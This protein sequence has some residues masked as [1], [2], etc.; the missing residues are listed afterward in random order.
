[1]PQWAIEEPSLAR[2]YRLAESAH[3]AQPRASD[4]RPFLDHVIE[5]A[6]LLR[7]AGLDT[8]LVA[9]GLLHD[10]VERGTLTEA[11]LR[12]EM[13]ESISS[14][15]M[16]LSEDPAIESF[17][18]RKAALR[19]QV[20]AA[21]DRAMTVFAA[22]KLSDILGLRRGLGTSGLDTLE[23]RLGTTVSSMTRHYEESVELVRSA[24]PESSFVPL[25]R[26]ELDRLR[27]DIP[28][29]AEPGA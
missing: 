18:A 17:G 29:P 3:G 5:V 22:D 6:T 27:A 14:L 2:A 25:L 24:C 7:R 16:A 19:D 1:M 21:G 28:T 10:S 13:G 11:A 9:V 8:E 20:A 26:D 12:S 23:A 15:V 4:G